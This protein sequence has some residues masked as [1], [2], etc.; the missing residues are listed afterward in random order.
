MTLDREPM[1]HV[2]NLGI[3]FRMDAHKTTSLKEW[4]IRVLKRERQ[5]YDFW[6]IRNISFDLF[7]GDVLGIIGRN[8]AGKSTLLKAVSGIIVPTEGTVNCKSPVVP[9]LE[10]GSGFD[11]ELSGTENIYLNGAVLGYQKEYIKERYQAIVDYA[12]IGDFIHMPLKVYSSGMIARLAFSIATVIRPEILIVD[13]ILAVGDEQFQ[14]KSY[15]RM[16]ELMTKGTTVLFVSHNIAQI[17]MMCSKTLWLHQGQLM[18]YGCTEEV[19][20]EYQH[21]LA[22]GNNVG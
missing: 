1:I 20:N 21:F 15:E 2:D 9:M 19:C 6:A 11:Y 16:M 12:E 3:C 8:G 18:Q 10:L 7:K 17:R 5:M 14:K 13:E 4:T 22:Q